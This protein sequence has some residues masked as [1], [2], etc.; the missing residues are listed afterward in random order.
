[1]LVKWHPV[2]SLFRSDRFIDH[3]FSDHFLPTAAVFEPKIEVKENKKDFTIQAELPGLNKD[4]FKLTIEGDVMTLEGEKKYEHE[5]KGDHFYRSERS[6]GAFKRA[7][8]LTDAIDKKK[9]SA[10]Y[11]NGILTITLPKSKTAV[12]KQIEI[13]VN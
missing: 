9:I 8:R 12:P 1:M 3:F 13:K 4:D 7:F 11:K 2:N 5:Q 10:D 6:Y